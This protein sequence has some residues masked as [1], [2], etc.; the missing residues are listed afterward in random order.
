MN[1]IVFPEKENIHS[2]D[3]VFQY[4]KCVNDI[5]LLLEEDNYE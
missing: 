2:T 5:V 1:V 4:Q 3:N